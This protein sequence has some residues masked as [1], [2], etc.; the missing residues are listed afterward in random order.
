MRRWSRPWARP[1]PR[2][3]ACMGTAVDRRDGTP[4]LHTWAAPGAG[5]PAWSLDVERG[6]RDPGFGGRPAGSPPRRLRRHR[7]REGR[8]DPLGPGDP[9][10][11]PYAV[12]ASGKGRGDPLGP[13]DPRGRPYAVTASGKGRGD[14]LGPATRGVARIPSPR[15]GRV[16]AIRWARA[17]RRVAPTAAPPSGRT[18]DPV[19]MKSD[20]SR[21]TPVHAPP[22][23]PI[24]ASDRDTRVATTAPRW[25]RVPHRLPPLS[26]VT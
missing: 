17:T 14:P 11:R 12:T 19:P 5:I 21:C 4:N 9:Q 24:A 2:D 6:R 8:G 15:P 7:V 23:A 26:R 16:V 13:G 3:N 20:C 18:R 10:G 22:P 25:A 1:P